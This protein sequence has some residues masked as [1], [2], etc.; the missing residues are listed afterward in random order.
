MP[1]AVT[2]VLSTIIVVDLFRDYFMKKIHHK[3]Y[4]TLN[5]ILVAG[6]A[7]LLPDIDIVLRM[8]S[9]LFNITIPLLFGHGYFT[10]TII[11]GLI[12]LIPGF[13]FW[14]KKKHKSATYFFVIS[15]AVLFHIFLDF[16]I[17]GGAHYGTML[18]WPFSSTQYK[19]HILS[20]FGLKDIPVALDAIFLLAWL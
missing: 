12:F 11:F 18:F 15:F 2:H 17:G 1:L 19:I 6:I 14:K 9:N 4:L 3:K 16:L 10:H 8:I 7:A 13:I 5:T 20:L